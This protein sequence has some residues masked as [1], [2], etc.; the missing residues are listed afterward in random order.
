MIK[1]IRL[2]LEYNTYCLWLYDENDEIVDNDNPPEWDDDKELTDA[3]MAVSNLYDTFFVDNG[4]EFRYCGCPNEKTR[5][6][7]EARIKAAVAILQQKNNG[8]YIIQNDIAF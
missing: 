4:K 5:A 2:L 7:L 1:K 6:E 8:K 3:F